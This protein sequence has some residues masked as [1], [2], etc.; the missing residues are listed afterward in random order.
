MKLKRSL[1]FVAALW[2]LI[3]PASAQQSIESFGKNRV[4][5]KNFEW[6]Y[7]STDNFD[8][9]FYEGGSDLAQ[10][11]ARYLEDEFD[12][13]TDVL[14]Y[15]PY[16]KTKLFLYNSVVD[17]Q[18]SNV[19]LNENNF[20]VGGQTNFVKSQLEL[21]YPGTVSEFKTELVYRFSQMLVNDMM[22]G[23]SL[24]DMFQNGILLTLPDWFM[25]GAAA[26]A[27]EGWSV[28]MDDYVRD[29]FTNRKFKKLSRFQ[30]RE[31]TLIGQSIW[32]F[33]AEYYGRS[34][35][36]YILNLTRIIRDEEKGI[37]NTLSI[38]FKRFIVEW[39]RYYHDMASKVQQNYQAPLADEKLQKKNRKGLAFSQV[40]ISPDSKY[41]AYVQNNHGRYRVVLQNKENGKS[42]VIFGG[43]YQVINQV[44]D[45]DTPIL[46]WKDENV[47][48]IIGTKSGR[49][50]LWQ[51]DVNSKSKIK[52]ELGRFNQI[53]SFDF[54]S[55]GNLVVM[56]ADINGRS[57]IFIISLKRNGL[58]RVTSDIYDD[59]DPK[60][61]P[62]T[63][64]IVFSSNRTT[65]T[66]NTKTKEFK[67]IDDNYNL[68]IYDIDTTKNVLFRATNTLSHDVKP[69][70]LN[71]NDIFY[72]SDQKGII[73]L[74]KYS[75]SDN[76]FVQMSDFNL[77]IQ[78][79][80]IDVNS[81]DVTFIATNKGDDFVYLKK[82]YDFN[83]SIFTSPTRR[84]EVLQAKYISQR[85]NVLNQQQKEV[86]N[87]ETEEELIGDDQIEI[88]PEE[89]VD[90]DIIDTDNYV[91]DK[92]VE[93]KEKN[94]SPIN[95]SFLSNYR[96]IQKESKILGPL[97]YETRF[98]ADNLITSWVI[99]PMRGFG[100][101]IEA[102]MNDMLE[103]HRFYGGILAI[104]DLKNSDLFTEYQFLKYKLDFNARYDR[105]VIFRESNSDNAISQR[106]TLNKFEVGV[107][108]PI[109][110]TSRISISPFYAQTRSFD[111]DDDLLLPGPV[112]EPIDTK[113]QYGGGKIEF[114][115]DNSV[116]NGLNL[117]EG[118]RAKASFTRYQSLNDIKPS[119]SKLT[120][121]IRNYQKIHRE[122]IFATRFFYGRFMGDD[123][124]R[125]LL[126]GMDNWLFKNTDSQESNDPLAIESERDNSNLLFLE[127][128]TNLRGF[129]YNKFNG[130]NAVLFNAELRLPI[131][132][133][134]SSGPV[135]SNFLRNLQFV[136][137]FDIG[138]SWNGSKLW[139]D[140]NSLNREVIRADGSP[141]EAVIDNFNS[142]WL[143]SYGAGM[144]TVLLGYYMKFDIAWPVE[145]YEVKSPKFYVTLGYDF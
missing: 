54:S 21:A 111:L 28:E 112:I 9:Y 99:D 97:P 143:S 3:N 96:K 42:K 95:N 11:A 68:F 115:Y 90:T 133:Y 29:L 127:Y 74:Y 125:F 77:N 41:I 114:V 51:Y 40:A 103:N 49:N 60:F 101:Q 100:I 25:D 38:P 138:S 91:F 55:S 4:Q 118:T 104:T 66:L 140:E 117:Y 6:R 142:P 20:T 120:V 131:V 121:D 76:L 24:T 45:Y 57:D 98:S 134:L 81:G 126:G 56:S 116:T 93:K 65:D 48:G 75:I 72:L 43:G 47:L 63:K 78:D 129:N 84:Q 105:K 128:V 86:I 70:P 87:N 50:Y 71:G 5:Y 122:F 23:G 8:V 16:S 132:K 1:F 26:Y 52:K 102:Q 139:P 15:S 82:N 106:Y 44:V 124:P 137:F 61:I 136:G 22:F 88:V 130:T 109:S 35:I 64:Q 67:D 107:S 10:I 94:D 135:S 119:F 27:A 19:G 7:Y 69:L 123:T 80:D 46:S 36:S 12:R 53:K 110:V 108:Y 73:N 79:Y 144:R 141:F 13:V 83:K 37:A 34:N 17:L 92:D 39:E 113:A 145:D 18:Q 58:K 14:G 89:E 59:V 31:A 30:G 2:F 33:I 32:N 62:N 85:I